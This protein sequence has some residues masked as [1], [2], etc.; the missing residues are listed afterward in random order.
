MGRGLKLRRIPLTAWIF[1]G[2]VAGVLLGVFAPSFARGLGPV[3]MVFLRLIKCIL[4]PLVFGTLVYG[5]AGAGDLKQ[6]GRI[7]LKAIVYFEVITTVALFIGLAAV[8][9]LRPGAGQTLKTG[10][11]VQALPAQTLDGVLEHIVPTSVIDAMARGDVLQIV[12]FSFLFGA[13]CLT[14]GAK[15]KPVVAFCGSLAE[16]MFRFTNYVMWLAPLGAGAALAVTIG[17]NGLGVLFGLGK[18]LATLYIALIFS[19]VIIFGSVIVLFRIPFARFIA[20]VRGP[21]LIAFSTASSEAAL[22]LA[23][24]NMEAFGVPPH[25]VGFVLPTGYS[26][27]LFGTTLYLSVASVFVAQAAGVTL[28]WG[29][30]L[31]MMLTLMLCSKGVAGIPRSA[32]VV[33]SGALVTFHLPMEGIAVLLGVDALMDMGRTAVNVMGNCLACAVVAR[34]EATSN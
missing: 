5:I 27:N 11:S 28:T 21:T 25:I 1:I 3:S 4:A 34:S 18:L 33:L 31:L 22:P 17:T 23:I 10:A 29:Q 13:A 14:V 2:M 20:A 26:F 9:L 6:M 19:I 24:E 12:V 7:G 32:I 15:A 8:N 30:Q 16:V